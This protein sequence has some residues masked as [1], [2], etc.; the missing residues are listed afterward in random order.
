MKDFYIC[1]AF[2]SVMR[3]NLGLSN[4]VILHKDGKTNLFQ[5]SK[6]LCSTYLLEKDS[7]DKLFQ[8]I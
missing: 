2:S 5:E 8:A 1:I 6:L 4:T 7:S 3:K